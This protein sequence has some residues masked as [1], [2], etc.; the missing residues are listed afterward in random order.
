MQRREEMVDDIDDYLK[1]LF[2][3]KHRCI[4]DQNT[5]EWGFAISND[6][7]GHGADTRG[8]TR[9]GLDF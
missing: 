1:T 6:K 7:W 8:N 2:D 5:N 9:V 3:R 4:P